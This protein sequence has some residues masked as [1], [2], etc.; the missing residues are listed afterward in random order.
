[1]V[2]EFEQILPAFPSEAGLHVTQEGQVLLPRVCLGEQVFKGLSQGEQDLFVVHR[3]VPALERK[4]TILN[5]SFC[6][7]KKMSLGLFCDLIF[8]NLWH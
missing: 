1:M 2:H 3:L 5:Y 8:K 7:K 6:S 4:T